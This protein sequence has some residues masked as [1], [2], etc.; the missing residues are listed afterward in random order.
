MKP[1]Y[2]KEQKTIETDV[3]DDVLIKLVI[4]LKDLPAGKSRAELAGVERL[5]ID[6]LLAIL[7]ESP[8]NINLKIVGFVRISEDKFIR[9]KIGKLNLLEAILK[10]HQVEPL[11]LSTAWRD[12]DNE[13]ILCIG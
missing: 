1:T 12:Q 10:E 6:E 2:L 13:N 9:I 4:P 3:T 5:R 11:V 7:R 8:A